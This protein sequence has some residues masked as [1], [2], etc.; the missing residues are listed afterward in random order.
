MN[1]AAA[2]DRAARPGARADQEEPHP[3]PPAHRLLHV[4]PMNSTPSHA[5]RPADSTWP[6]SGHGSPGQ[7]GRR[8]WRSL[9]EL[10]ET[11]EF[12]AYP[13]PRVSRRRPRSGPTRPAGGRSCKLMGASLALAGVSGLHDVGAAPRRSCPTSGS[14]RTSCRASRS[15]TPRRSRSAGYA[16]GVLVESH[17]GRPTMVE[18]NEKHPDSLGAI[19]PLT[20]ATVLDALRPR[21]LAGRHDAAAS[22][23][24]WD[25]FLLAAVARARRAAGHEG[26][27][28]ADPDRDGHL[29]DAGAADPR[30]ARRSSPR[31]SGTST[32]PPAA[33]TPARAA[34]LAFGT[35]RHGPL[36]RRQGR[37][38]PRARRRLPR[39]RPRPALADAREF[40]ARR[41]PPG[42]TMNRLYAVE[43]TPTVTGATADHRLP[44]PAH[45][46]RRR[47]RRRSRGSWASRSR[48]R[49]P[50]RP[51]P[52]SALDRRAGRATSRRTRGKSL[53]MAGETQPAFVHAL[54]HAINEA[55]GNVG[56]TVEYLEPVEAEP[57]DQV[58]SLRR[59]CVGDMEAGQVDAAPRSSA[60]TPPTTR[61]PTSASPRRSEKVALQRPPGPVRRRDLGAVPLARPRGA[62]AGGLGRRRGRSTARRRSSSP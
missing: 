7:T 50:R 12:L 18:G 8:F 32:S 16:T 9:E 5:T 33:T 3:G 13:P 48:R 45:R 42:G 61:R 39:H 40:A 57:V 28:A 2:E 49:T 30:P 25:G 51:T 11:E 34:E 19:D 58:A 23:S 36:P 14:P 20:Q 43:P 17:M 31:R 37:R 24:T 26:G 4:P 59:R 10:A 22:I 46:G 21:P 38:D 27:G 62:R 47:S 29:A 1:W 56:K 44:L 52:R 35:R 60:A 15:T 54:A 55:L 41:E 6:P 53:V